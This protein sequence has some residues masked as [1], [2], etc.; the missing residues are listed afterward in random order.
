MEGAPNLNISDVPEMMPGAQPSATSV[1]RE[2][3]NRRCVSL[4]EKGSGEDNRQTSPVRAVYQNFNVA[5]G[6]S[7]LQAAFPNLDHDLIWN[8]YQEAQNMQD[9]VDTLLALSAS[10]SSD[11]DL[12]SGTSPAMDASVPN[13]ATNQRNLEDDGS[14]WPALVGT[15]G[16]EIVNCQALEHDDLGSA[17]CKTAKDAVS[18]PA[19]KPVRHPIKS[20]E[21]KLKPGK[22]MQNAMPVMDN[23]EC[24]ADDMPTDYD[25]RH[26]RG[27][28]RANKLAI[29][30]AARI[31]DQLCK[32]AADQQESVVS[33]S[34]DSSDTIC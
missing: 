5:E 23:A 2:R 27:Q 16:W 9:A 3:F 12:T 6:H 7:Q 24:N 34:G 31:T 15:D 32:Y 19:P 11:A 29:K 8:T 33:E 14:S 13:L 1:E 17:W 21:P 20:A 22:Q 18:L 28:M 26:M 30:A 4:W 25:L 10:I